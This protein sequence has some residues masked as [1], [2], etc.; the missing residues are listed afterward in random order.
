MAP[1]G[2]GAR[3]TCR[4]GAP[5]QG[6]R[7]SVR[8]GAP[9]LPGGE[10][11]GDGGPIP[12]QLLAGR[13]DCQH[14]RGKGEW[15]NTP[16][17]FWASSPSP[18]PR[19]T[20]SP[21]QNSAASFLSSVED[22]EVCHLPPLLSPVPFSPLAPVRPVSSPPCIP[23][24]TC[25]FLTLRATF[26]LCRPPPLPPPP[27]IVLHVL[28][29]LQVPSACDRGQQSIA[30]ALC[31]TIAS[32]PRSRR[33]SPSRPSSGSAG[34]SPSSRKA[35]LPTPTSQRC[36]RGG[37]KW[38]PLPRPAWTWGWPRP[39]PSVPLW[40]TTSRKQRTCTLRTGRP[41]KAPRV[42]RSGGSTWCGLLPPS[43]LAPPAFS[44]GPHR[45]LSSPLHRPRPSAI[46]SELIDTKGL[47][48]TPQSSPPC[49]RERGRAFLR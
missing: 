44:W 35:S 25:P 17:G 8:E 45:P 33:G 34:A 42:R 23:L 20:L 29:R 31:R 16:E 26:P 32:S 21:L 18:K 13:S 5:S 28:K 30:L 47:V 46:R 3:D 36:S 38:F 39:W 48:E 43:P 15:A 11:L 37:R 9:R 24:L 27:S 22:L 10:V 2:A 41:G 14:P 1:S 40:S 6:A 7:G 4:L 49:N 19:V 12:R